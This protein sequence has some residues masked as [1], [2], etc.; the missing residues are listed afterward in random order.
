[1]ILAGAQNVNP[2]LVES[3]RDG[4]TPNFIIDW[5]DDEAEKS[6]AMVT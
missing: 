2:M 6:V 1:L 3:P 5:R 4:K